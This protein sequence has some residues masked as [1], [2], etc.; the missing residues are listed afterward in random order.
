MK[1]YFGNI[2]NFTLDEL[3]SIV[4]NNKEL[5]FYYDSFIICPILG[6]IKIHNWNNGNKGKSMVR[7]YPQSNG[8]W[9][10]K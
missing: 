8:T 5:G 6:N 3:K 1:K 7:F 4:A 2:K 9:E 10:R